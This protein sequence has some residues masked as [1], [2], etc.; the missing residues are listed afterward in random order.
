VI[1]VY[2]VFPTYDLARYISVAQ[3]LERIQILIVVMWMAGIIVKMAVFFHT[4]A[5]AAATTLGLKNYRV[6]LLPIFAGTIV[7][8]RVFYGDYLRLTDFLFNIFPY[9]GW[10]VELLIPALLFP[11]KFESLLQ[12]AVRQGITA[13]HYKG[14]I[15]KC[16]GIFY[17][18]C[19]AQ[20]GILSEIGQV[21]TIFPAITE[22]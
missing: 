2:M 22:I 18:S 12:I 9:Y 10:A 5:I 1:P 14:F 15:Q 16:S 20:W 7:I 8:S 13:D 19:C 17:T 21:Y 11:M 4:S 6:T 3:F